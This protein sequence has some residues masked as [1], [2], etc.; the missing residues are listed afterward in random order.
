MAKDAA[1]N[2]TR[3]NLWTAPFIL[4]LIVGVIS[5]AAT[6][7]VNPI[8]MEYA[9]NLGVSNM[10]FATDYIP[11]SRMGEGIGWFGLSVIVA[12]AFGPGLGVSLADHYS[13]SA[14]FICSAALYAASVALM[15]AIPAKASV[16]DVSRKE[17]GKLS[18]SSFIEPRILLPAICLGMFSVVNSLVGNY[19]KLIATERAIV[20]LAVG[21]GAYILHTLIRGRKA[22]A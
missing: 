21:G 20:L 11:A 22:A 8:I 1:Q 16:R 3:E 9:V 17:T 4:V 5:G 12:Q 2:Q 10:A 15:F 7:M 13:Y 14:S 6:Q 18:M 19:L